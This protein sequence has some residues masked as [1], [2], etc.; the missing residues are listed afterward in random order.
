MKE[1]KN[2]TL[3][4]CDYC[5][6]RLLSKAGAKLHE[7]QYCWVTRAKLKKEKQ[8]KCEHKAIY[9]AWRSM[10]PGEAA[11]E[12]DHDYCANCGKIM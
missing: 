11:K 4:Q 12:P 6:K 1:I 5:G 9:T 2:Q 8:E 10:G 3:Y 7:E